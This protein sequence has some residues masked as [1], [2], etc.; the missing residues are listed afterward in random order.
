MHQIS[1]K[2]S[3]KL[4][5]PGPPPLINPCQPSPCGDYSKC[6]VIDGHP[7]CSCQQNYIGTPPNCRPECLVSTDCANNKACINQLCQ[8]PCVG[9]CGLNTDCQVINHSPV[10]SCI[11]GYSGDPFYGCTRE[12]KRIVVKDFY[13][14]LIKIRFIMMKQNFA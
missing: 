14:K 7:V 2:Y 6:Q 11:S 12:G 4:D 3:L 8:D 13:L 9:T 10:C 5:L 1:S